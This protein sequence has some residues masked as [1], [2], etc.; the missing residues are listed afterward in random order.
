M[1]SVHLRQQFFLPT[2]ARTQSCPISGKNSAVPISGTAVGGKIK[3]AIALRQQLRCIFREMSH[4]I[5]SIGALFLI[6]AF[7]HSFAYERSGPTVSPIARS[8]F[9]SSRAGRRH[10]GKIRLRTMWARPLHQSQDRRGIG[11]RAWRPHPIVSESNR[12]TKGPVDVAGGVSRG[13]RDAGRRRTPRST[14]GSLCRHSIGS[15]T[16]SLYSRAH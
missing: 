7:G 3:H 9:Q 1:R 2:Y 16:G 13:A 14:R 11:R 5:L 8:A 12:T 4:P 6:A 15:L 10:T